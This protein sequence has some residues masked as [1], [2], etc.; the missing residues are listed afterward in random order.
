MSAT[1][2]IET[3][4]RIILAA[5]SSA[6]SLA[7]LT[8]EL[9]LA[10]IAPLLIEEILFRAEPAPDIERTEVAVQIT[11]KGETVDFVLTL[12]SG[13]LIKAEQR[14]VGDVPL[15]IGY[16]L[17][18]LIAELFGPGAP[19]AVGARSTSFLRTTTSG[20]IP[21]P[22]ELSDGFQA[23][24][25]VVA[26]CGHRRP[27]LNLLASHYRTDKWGGLH[28]FTPLYERHLGEF[29]DRPVRI[30]EIGVGGYNFDGGGG[31]SLKMWKRYFHRGLVFGMDVFD[32]SFLDQQ[33]LCTVR[34]DQSKPEELAAV[35]DKYGPF[36]IIIDD[37][38]HING[39]VRTS[40]ETLFPRLRSGGV[41]V[42]EDLWTTYAPGFGGQAQCPA[43]PGTTV[44]L[45]KNLLEGV[46]HEEQP[47]AGSYEPSYLER[48]LV[49]LHIYH[50]IAFLEK[51]VNAEG[52][53]PAWV[54]RSLDDILHLADVNSAE[55]E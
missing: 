37:G 34:A 45:L 13:E 26:G 33:R 55:D 51:G 38:S 53:V 42:I 29:R 31:E 43:A 8:T 25:A 14:P 28:W 30:L 16:E 20:S 5:G 27:D 6:A 32:K 1:H 47:H 50:N 15:R 23:I 54:P 17:T 52:G 22:S 46:Q 49:G 10:R 18:D 41:Y 2:E 3:V 4:E 19:R 11:H 40:L 39:H 48:N 36:D 21:G 9:G 24:S 12:Q 7:D 35:D 44:S